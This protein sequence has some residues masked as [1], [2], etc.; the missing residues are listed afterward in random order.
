MA[1]AA[2]GMR[3]PRRWNGCAVLARIHYKMG[4]RDREMGGGYQGRYSRKGAEGGVKCSNGGGRPSHQ[5]RRQ[6]APASSSRGPRSQ[7]IPARSL[8]HP[9][10]SK[11]RER[12]TRARPRRRRERLLPAH[13]RQRR[14][15]RVRRS[16]PLRFHAFN[17][18][19]RS[20]GPGIARG[21]FSGLFYP[22][23]RSVSQSCAF[24]VGV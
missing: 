19:R 18:A 10:C 6:G 9:F 1:R 22:A 12:V 13:R 15:A 24:F 7:R 11:S 5:R 8:A 23:A 20:G 17:R 3:D 4:E 14:H 21:P 16:V 2:Q